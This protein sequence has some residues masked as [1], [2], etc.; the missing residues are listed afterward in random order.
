MARARRRER[1]QIATPAVELLDP[2]RGEGER[3]DRSELCG[4]QGHAPLLRAGRR[5]VEPESAL[6]ELLGYR[7]E[8]ADFVGAESVLWTGDESDRHILQSTDDSVEPFAAAVPGI[9]QRRRLSRLPEHRQ[10]DLSRPAVE[11]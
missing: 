1:P 9:H 3:R 4:N 8:H 6:S 5:G 11:V 2:A 10:L 7:T